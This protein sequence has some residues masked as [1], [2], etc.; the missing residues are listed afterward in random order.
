[1]DF[2]EK[3]R[4]CNNGGPWGHVLAPLSQVATGPAAL[5][6]PAAALSPCAHQK[7]SH[8]SRQTPRTTAGRH[9]SKYRYLPVCRC[10]LRGFRAR[11]RAH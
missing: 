5:H 2:T 9:C 7:S 1:M 11:Q 4:Y 6:A 8:F 3:L 10:S